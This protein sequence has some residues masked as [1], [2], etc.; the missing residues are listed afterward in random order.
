MKTIQIID[1][2]E[3]CA[4]DCF[5]ADDELFEAIFPENG[6]DIEF[7][8]DFLERVSDGSCDS[9]FALMWERRVPKKGIKGIDGSL[10]YELLGKKKFYPNKRDSDLKR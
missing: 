10:Y 7:I 5:L 8:E 6:Q 2:A 1:G 9:L 4:Y 3:N